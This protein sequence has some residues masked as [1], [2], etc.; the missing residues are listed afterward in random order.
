MFVGYPLCMVR[1]GGGGLCGIVRG[2]GDAAREE[3][4]DDEQMD[5][6]NGLSM[7]EN[8]RRSRAWKYRI[9]S[10]WDPPGKQCHPSW[11]APQIPFH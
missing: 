6:H 9:S 5:F 8:M 2:I 11:L 4:E 1:V 10:G 3:A 7:I